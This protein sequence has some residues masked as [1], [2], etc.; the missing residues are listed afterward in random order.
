MCNKIKMRDGD[1]MLIMVKD[2]N[3]LHY[4]P[5]M[6]LPHSEFVKRTTGQLPEG[7]WVGTVSKLDGEIAAISS[8]H[9]FG[10]QLP[11]PDWVLTAVRNT[12]E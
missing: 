3:I 12:F 11:A 9:F 8:K 5:N 6:C 10:Y 1:T 2:A 7:A 4:T